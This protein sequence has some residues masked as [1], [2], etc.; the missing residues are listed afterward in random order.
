MST[1]IFRFRRL[2]F[3]WCMLFGCL[4]FAQHALP[5]SI[6]G[7]GH[8]FDIP[9][10]PLHQGILEFA[11]QADCEVI[12]QEQDLSRLQGRSVRGYHLP[13][14]A[15][16]K[17]L[18]DARLSVE[19]LTAAKAYVIRAAPVPSAS[20]TAPQVHVIEEILVTGQRYPVRYQ[21][22]V[23]TEDRY[24]GAMFDSTR[25]HNILPAAVLE[26]SA[27][28][29]LME[30]L[31]YLSSATP[32]DGFAD[33]NDDYFIRGFSRQNTYINGLRLS[34]NTAMQ[35]V[36]DTVKRLDVLKGPSMLFYGQ[37]SAGGVVDITRKQPA[38]EDRLRM[39]L[40]LGEPSRHKLFIEA[41]KAQ[42]LG[43]IDFLLMGMEDKDQESADGQERH[44]QMVNLSGKG[45]IDDRIVY[46]AGYEYQYL[47]KANALDLPV[48]SDAGQFL[49]YQGRDFLNQADNNFL[50][51][52]ELFDGSLSYTLM[53]EWLIQ[54]NFLWQRE[55]RDGVRTGGNFLTNSHVFLDP[56]SA[57]PRVGV[58]A[59]MGQLT[60]PIS[61]LGSNYTFGLV[62]SIYDQLETENSLTASLAL[63]GRLQTGGVE[64]R[65]I[66]GADIY[67]QSLKQEFAV[68]KRMFAPR[69]VFSKAILETPQTMLIETMLRAP[70]ATRGINLRASDVTRNDWGSYF[71]VRSSWTTDWNTSLGWRYSHFNEARREIDGSN[72]DLEGSYDDWLL[73]VGT[74][75]LMTDTLSFYSN[76]SETLNLN[77]L[78]DDSSRFV[79]QPERSQ[80]Q[81][82]GF[83]WQAPDGQLLSTLSLFDIKSSGIN[84]VAFD[85]GYRTLQPPQQHKVQGI[86]L[87]LTWRMNDRVE[88]IASVGLMRNQLSKQYSS[89]GY[90]SMVAD[91]TLGILGRISLTDSWA[92]YAGFNYVSD[93]PIG[94]LGNAKLGEYTLVDMSLEKTLKTNS[95]EWRIRVIGKNLLDEYHPSIAIPGVRVNPTSGRQALI[96]FTYEFQK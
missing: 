91:N 62:E 8:Y 85:S 39:D 76:Y 92:Y 43:N 90:P 19:Y 65:L 54:G 51:S 61:Q 17:L 26:D 16:Q 3:K 27:S 41:N 50:A 47:N 53:P 20:P 10:L 46:S 73:Q 94:D 34:N 49:P 60:A 96:K 9:E 24:G 2:Y 63:N 59:L 44:R 95:N 22:V 57:L 84:S 25:A 13:L 21:T 58:A 12:A 11:F 81:E 88:W 31:R 89:A 77:Y 70:P 45:T 32:G 5:D 86:E 80:Q 83:R 35:V 69:P 71:Q 67:N 87:D 72:P 30:A 15:L 55:Y 93:R 4:S 75:W 78:V 28:D 74:S 18:A 66:A 82:L 64:H 6:T 36:P 7:E 23:S 56:N 14:Q 48:F 79:E 1:R 33:S 29:S 38:P 68:E 52:A 40:T 37:S 42:L